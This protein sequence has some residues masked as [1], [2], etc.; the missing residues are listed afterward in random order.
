MTQISDTTVIAR[1]ERLERENKRLKRGVALVV[2]GIGAIFVM[3]QAQSRPRTLEAE[4]LIIRHANGQPAVVLETSRTDASLNLYAPDGSGRVLIQADSTASKGSTVTV[5]SPKHEI[6][7]ELD[8]RSMPES[9][10]LQVNRFTR[11]T[12][13]MIAL[14][15]DTSGETSL[16]LYGSEGGSGTT[17]SLMNGPGSGTS[18]RL[19]NIAGGMDR[20]VLGNTYLENSRTGSKETTPLSSLVLFDKEGKV[21][22]KAP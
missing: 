13:P 6:G 7:I 9:V 12:M 3:A 1:I 8:A 19:W 4:R 22:W 16:D 2:V 14:G 15:A 11:T 20:A 17:L 10:G 18:L 21:L 5:L